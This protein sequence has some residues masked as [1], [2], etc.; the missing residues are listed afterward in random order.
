MR[1]I[2][3]LCE[4]GIEKSITQ[5]CW[6]VILGMHFYLLPSQ[7]YDNLHLSKLFSLLE[8]PCNAKLILE[9]YFF[10]PSPK[11]MILIIC[12]SWSPVHITYKPCDAKG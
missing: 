2:H 10:Y 5:Q 6:I 11:L 3:Y 4:D 7:D 12:S 8:K 1:R 9:T